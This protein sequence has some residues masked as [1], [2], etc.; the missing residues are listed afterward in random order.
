V[1]PER[2]W[3]VAHMLV[4]LVDLPPAFRLQL[5]VPC[6]CAGTRPAEVFAVK[7]TRG[8]LKSS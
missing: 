1:Q 4:L 8:P 2:S 7:V 3:Q 6:H 5:Q